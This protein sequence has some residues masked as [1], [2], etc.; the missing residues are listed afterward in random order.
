MRGAPRHGTGALD[1]EVEGMGTVEGHRSQVS[2]NTK[3]NSGSSSSNKS[4]KGKVKGKGVGRLD[5]SGIA[6]EA[7]EIDT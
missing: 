1:L 4:G 3:V 7:G 2:R 6:L 5:G